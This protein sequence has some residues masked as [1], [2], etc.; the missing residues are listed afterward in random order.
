[1]SHTCSIS[2]RYGQ[3]DEHGNKITWAHSRYCLVIVVA[4]GQAMSVEKWG[5]VRHFTGFSI[6]KRWFTFTKVGW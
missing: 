6:V 4:C 3:R 1:M 2:D 5:S